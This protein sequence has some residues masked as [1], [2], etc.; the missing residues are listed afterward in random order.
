MLKG[1]TVRKEGWEVDRQG[2]RKVNDVDEEGVCDGTREQKSDEV[3][4]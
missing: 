3:D 1:L 4:F 2:G